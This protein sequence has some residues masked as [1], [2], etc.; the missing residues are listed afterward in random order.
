MR[1][2]PEVKLKNHCMAFE[3]KDGNFLWIDKEDCDEIAR[4]VVFTGVVNSEFTIVVRH[5]TN[6]HKAQQLQ[7]ILNKEKGMPPELRIQY[8][9]EILRLYKAEGESIDE[10]T[11]KP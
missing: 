7:D 4:R 9:E 8:Y 5:D 3:L 11:L 6:I 10:K 2:Q 1:L